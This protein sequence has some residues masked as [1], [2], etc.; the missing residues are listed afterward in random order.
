MSAAFDNMANIY[1]RAR[2]VSLLASL[3]ILVTWDMRIL[4]SNGYLIYK[5]M[6]RG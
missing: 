1:G 3:M 4:D 2:P 6:I 5:V